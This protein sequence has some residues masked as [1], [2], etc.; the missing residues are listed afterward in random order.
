ML[1]CASVV[2]IVSIISLLTK[3]DVVCTSCCVQFLVQFKFSLFINVEF[4]LSFPV[5]SGKNEL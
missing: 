3:C 4:K 2:V 1:R 5:L